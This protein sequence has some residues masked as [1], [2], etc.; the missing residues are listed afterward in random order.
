[1]DVAKPCSRTGPC[2]IDHYLHIIFYVRR[3]VMSVVV[4]HVEVAVCFPAE[5]IGVIKGCN[6]RDSV[7]VHVSPYPCVNKDAVY[8]A[9]FR[10]TV[11]AFYV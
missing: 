2:G 11:H 8:L 4:G 3:V 7:C 9:V 1:M 6:C 5:L 10:V